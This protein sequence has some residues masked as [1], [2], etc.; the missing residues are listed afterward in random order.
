MSDDGRS[1]ITENVVSS[2]Y[3]T[4]PTINNNEVECSPCPIHPRVARKQLRFKTCH[5]GL[6]A[7]CG[8]ASIHGRRSLLQFNQ[9]ETTG[10]R[11]FAFAQACILQLVQDKLLYFIF[12][13]REQGISAKRCIIIQ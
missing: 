11:E 2:L 4:S 8:D 13:L 7:V 9:Q 10:P 5:L 1:M 12:E 6:R 3:C